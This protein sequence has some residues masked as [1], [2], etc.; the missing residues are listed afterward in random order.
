MSVN[1]PKPIDNTYRELLEAQLKFFQAL[2]AGRVTI[3]QSPGGKLR[4]EIIS[5][6]IF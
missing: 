3:T 4:V 1:D 5:S 6:G 2:N